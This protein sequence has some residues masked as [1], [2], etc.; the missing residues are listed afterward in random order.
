MK[1]IAYFIICL[2]STGQHA[3]AQ[4]IGLDDACK[5]QGMKPYPRL[6]EGLQAGSLYT[7][8]LKY[9]TP[10]QQYCSGIFEGMNDAASTAVSDVAIA[11]TGSGTSAR[12][13]GVGLSL[14]GGI[15]GGSSSAKLDASV[16]NGYD[17]KLTTGPL[18][19]NGQTLQGLIRF[20]LQPGQCLKEIQASLKQ[21][22]RLKVYLLFQSAQTDSLEYSVTK[23]RN[24]SF[25][26]GIDIP[27][28]VSI[29]PNYKIENKTASS[30][31]VRGK[32]NVCYVWQKYTLTTATMVGPGNF[33]LSSGWPATKK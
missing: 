4:T 3:F 29:N 32:T 15:L 23:T 11:G 18:V 31:A 2:I 14:L 25:S 17:W 21:N 10:A 16:S 7:N 12:S 13:G 26:L 24:D 19:A 6:T 8:K 30:F 5:T 27:T 20:K 33:Q 1:K 28:F 9:P 22:K